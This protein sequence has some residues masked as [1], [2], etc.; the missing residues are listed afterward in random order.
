MDYTT[1]LAQAVETT[2]RSQ[3]AQQAV[4]PI[5]SIWQYVTS[6]N[7]LEA[8]TFI[9]FG[10]VCLFYG[11]RVFKIL[12]II[13]FSLLGLLLGIAITDRLNGSD[14]H[15]LGGII[16]LGLTGVLSVPLMRW[17]VSI[18][19]A[20]AGGT[21]TAGIWYACNLPEPYIWAGALVGVVA[22][23]MISFIIFKIAVMLFSCLGGSALTVTGVLALL[24][25]YPATQEQV[26]E[27]VFTQKWFLPAALMVPTA[28]GIFVQ[29][30][31]VKCSKDWSV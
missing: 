22:G 16:G 13:S 18:L 7:L 12:V 28:I 31:F 19:G 10:V 23:G 17:A 2:A 29:N 21:V 11:W 30:R 15:L 4:V 25:L 14:S 5:D 3:E 27:L 1:I 6:L 20:I 9:S 8:L 26:Q 24:Y